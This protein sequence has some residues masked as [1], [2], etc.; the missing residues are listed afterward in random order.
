MRIFNPGSTAVDLIYIPLVA[1]ASCFNFVSFSLLFTRFPLE[2]LKNS[3]FPSFADNCIRP[4]LEG[5][6]I[7]TISRG[8]LISFNVLMTFELSPRSSSPSVISIIALYPPAAALKAL[9][10]VFNAF[11]IFVLPTGILSI[12]MSFKTV[13]K[14]VLSMVKG[15]SRK[16]EPAKAIIPYL[17]SG[18]F[19]IRFFNRSL[20]C[21]SLE[22]RISFDSIL[23]ETS[24]TARISL[25]LPENGR[26]LYPQ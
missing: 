22:G 10:A 14:L 11:S 15:H 8:V 4:G 16:A 2:S 25:P 3:D 12:L 26:S 9:I 24:I 1:C 23:F 18:V 7:P 20:A 17:S 5:S 21:A 13:Y 19:L 6:P